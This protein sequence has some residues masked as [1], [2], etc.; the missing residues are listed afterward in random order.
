[1]PAL[2]TGA[3]QNEAGSG[4]QQSASLRPR[5]PGGL[6][7]LTCALQQAG[8]RAAGPSLE[9]TT[10]S[11][12]FREVVTQCLVFSSSAGLSTFLAVLFLLVSC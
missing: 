7:L 1:M 8:V 4:F 2:K 5:A 11:L 9:M 12:V 6:F 3:Y 10:G